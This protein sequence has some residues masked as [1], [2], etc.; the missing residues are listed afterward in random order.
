[1]AIALFDV[2]KWQTT[3]D[4]RTG[5]TV[6]SDSRQVNMMRSILDRHPYPGDVNLE[7]NRWVTDIALNLVEEYQPGF[8]FLSYSQ[9]YFSRRFSHLPG[10]EWQQMV[11]HVFDEIARFERESGFQALVVGSGEMVPL[12]GYIDLSQLDGV[13][14]ASNWSTTYAGVYDP[15]PADLEYVQSHPHIARVVSQAE[16]VSHFHNGEDIRPHLPDF[17]LMA[18]EGYA[19]K[20]LSASLRPLANLTAWNHSIPVSDNLGEVETITGVRPLIEANF[21]TRKTALVIVEGIGSADFRRSHQMSKNGLDWH[22]YEPGEGQFLALT[23]GRHQLFSFPPGY[24]YYPE[25]GDSKEYPFSSYFDQLPEDTVAQAY[26]GKSI[27]VGN[28][29]MFMH[30]TSGANISVECFSRGL[31][32]H[33]NMAVIGDGA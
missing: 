28:R 20:A 25:D 5:Q 6:N 1:M 10:E 16:F 2:R 22:F 27:A 7:S 4:L 19:F 31:Y 32:N 26:G 3:V 8:V 23:T 18:R 29:S 30:M 33:G 11:G 14:T 9:L 21:R 12:K 17:L 13:A 24:L 15:S